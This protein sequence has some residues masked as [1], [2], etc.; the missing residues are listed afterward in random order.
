MKK[1]IVILICLFISILLVS[2]SS[3]ASSDD[4]AG[5]H[6]TS[7]PSSTNTKNE[8][9]E[10]V[11]NKNGDIITGKPF[12]DDSNIEKIII[13]YFGQTTES[14][15]DENAHNL[16]EA[17]KECKENPNVLMTDKVGKISVKYKGNDEAVDLA[18]L[19]IS[20]D[21]SVYAQYIS[22]SKNNYLYKIDQEMFVKS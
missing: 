14:I 22:E 1:S 17:I 11:G 7:S 4:D 20:T 5:Q 9:N 16:L 6:S 13:S 18:R 21:Y 8:P 19:Y 10:T 2:C 15:Y 12:D 3:Q